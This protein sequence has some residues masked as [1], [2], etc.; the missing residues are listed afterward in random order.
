MNIHLHIE[1]LM[2]D[3][4]PVTDGEGSLVQASLQAELRRVLTNHGLPGIHG[5]AMV[6]LSAGPMNLPAGTG[7]TLLG[8]HIART[9][10]GG[11]APQAMI[12]GG[13]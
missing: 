11:L 5:G 13:R 10:Y 6:Q 8:E 4:L 3:G 7:P 9:L 2:L 12:R 1:Q